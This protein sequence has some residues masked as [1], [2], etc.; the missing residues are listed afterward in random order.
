MRLH[1]RNHSEWYPFWCSV[2][3]QE[4]MLHF[5]EKRNLMRKRP[6]VQVAPNGPPLKQMARKEEDMR[7]Y[8][9]L[10]YQRGAVAALLVGLL[11]AACA[12]GTSASSSSGSQV[13]GSAPSRQVS[14]PVTTPTC[15]YAA[16][17]P[18]VEATA[19]GAEVSVVI[20]ST[21]GFPILAGYLV[22]IRWTV[23][24]SGPLHV[25]AHGPRGMTLLPAQGPS[26]HITPP[27]EWGTV[28]TFPVAGC[29]NLH[30]TR[31]HAAGDI[32]LDVQ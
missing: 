27:N 3:F 21:T 12:S 8:T 13:P 23:A 22:K 24:G 31:D 29:W 10:F 11:L 5:Q 2:S 16:V 15:P 26:E 17:G 9:P 1:Q 30:V 32:W 7:Q 18:N 4:E 20:E 19:T 28:F 25:V 6:T 14:P